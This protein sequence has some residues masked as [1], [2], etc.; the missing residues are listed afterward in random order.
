M[1]RC[2]YDGCTTSLCR[3]ILCAIVGGMLSLL[4]LAS[5]SQTSTCGVTW[6]APIRI[7]TDS[8]PSLSTR[9]SVTG[10]TIHVFWFGLDT[11][12]TVGEDG[13]QYSHSFD[14]GRTFATPRSLVSMDTAFPPVFIA[15]AG[16]FVYAV[17]PASID[18]FY[19]S[20]LIR[21][22]DAGISWGPVTLLGNG[23]Q[24]VCIAA[25]N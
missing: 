21:S 11:L 6:D 2:S 15:S 12:G 17:F 24:P 7:S 9:I 22:I 25:T 4:P 1:L 13:I 3:R 20:V 19:G 23:L 18:T 10:D 16:Q 8:I 5:F 14:G